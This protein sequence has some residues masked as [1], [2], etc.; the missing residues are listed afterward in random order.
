MNQKHELLPKYQILAYN[1]TVY[2]K[3]I[4]FKFKKYTR[5]S[6]SRQKY[7]GIKN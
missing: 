7:K 6:L 4:F 1:F 5:Q 3:Y 2:R